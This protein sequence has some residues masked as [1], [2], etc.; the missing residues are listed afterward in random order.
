MRVSD[1]RSR[2]ALIQFKRQVA[3]AFDACRQISAWLATITSCV[4]FGACA[5]KPL[6]P[7][8]ADTPPMVLMPASQA[9]VMDK[10]GRFREIYCAVLEARGAALPDY[11]PCEQALTRVGA[12]SPGTGEPVELG[13][14]RRHLIGAVVH[15]VGYDCFDPWL[16][17]PDTVVT[18]LR[19][20]GFDAAL[21]NVDALSSS[22]NNAR[23]IRDAIMAM[24]ASEDA[25]R[26]VL[27]GYSKG[28]PD[29]LEAL[30]AYP[31]IRS[32][33]AAVVSAAGAI[34]GSP[35]ANDADQYQADLLRYVPGA[36]CTSG[37]GGAVESLRPATR[38]AWLA[39]HPLP[40]DLHY[41]SVVTFPQPERISSILKSSYD[42]LARVDSRNDSQVIFYDQVVPGSTLL[43]YVNADHWALAVPVAR[44][45][46]TIGAL[47]VTQNA[48]PREALAEAILR[49]LEEDLGVPIR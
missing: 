15:G 11:R 42:K 30:V 23:Q 46:P 24:P 35:L 27:I 21:I 29:I 16:D 39:Q 14:S 4:L 43:A 13:Q 36:T 19:E 3:A 33:V 31:E 41:Y 8:S 5:A 1:S 9:G 17:T 32:R 49:F 44:T 12:E 37:D 2:W 6:I 20:Y 34:G 10:R 7:Y 22:T 48:Y 40:A 38:K 18:H 25:P 45:H 26:L 28:A 47:F